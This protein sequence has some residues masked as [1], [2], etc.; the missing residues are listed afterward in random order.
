MGR[1]QTHSTDRCDARKNI[2]MSG[3]KQQIAILLTG[4]FVWAA[5]AKCPGSGALIHAKCVSIT[6]SSS[7]DSVRH[8]ILGRL[9][10]TNGW[11]D[12]HNRGT[13]VFDKASTSMVAGH[14]LAAKGG[15]TDKFMF[16]LVDGN[17]GC[18]MK[19]CSESQG[20]SV[21]DYGTNYCNLHNLFC[22]SSE[23]C[24]P[25]YSDFRSTESLKSC[26]FHTNNCLT[27]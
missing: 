6:A 20:Y 22:G 8:E 16:E 2:G 7:C 17:D 19:A 26:T 14:R 13:Y 11:Y 15:Y 3:L 27:V 10:G 1:V 23:G 4:I 24:K 18:E 12:P 5:N 21:Y 25:V 9:N